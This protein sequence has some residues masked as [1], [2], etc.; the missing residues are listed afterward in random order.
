[1]TCTQASALSLCEG[2]ADA[3]P[4]LAFVESWLLPAINVLQEQGWD[5]LLALQEVQRKA[6]AAGG[7]EAARMGDAAATLHRLIPQV[8]TPT[9]SHFALSLSPLQEGGLCIPNAKSQ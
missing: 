6:A 1:L 5:M 3:A 4:Q 7:D 8:G 2:F 9:F